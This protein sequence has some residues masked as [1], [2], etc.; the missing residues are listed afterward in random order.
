MSE[1]TL[2]G[3]AL[4]IDKTRNM[5]NILNYLQTGKSLTVVECLTRHNTSELRHYISE[6]QKTGVKVSREWQ[7]KGLMKW[8]RYWIER[9]PCNE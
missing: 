1:S 7:Y 4:P 6:I 8:K 9:E 5:Q 2:Y 3:L